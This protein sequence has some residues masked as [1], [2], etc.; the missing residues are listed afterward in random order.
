MC[1]TII[2]KSK[3]EYSIS[4]ALDIKSKQNLPVLLNIRYLKF[5]QDYP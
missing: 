3:K 4:G 5:L 2:F 1:L